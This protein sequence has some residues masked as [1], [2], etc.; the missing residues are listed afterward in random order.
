MNTCCVKPSVLTAL[1][2]QVK[3]RLHTHTQSAYFLQKI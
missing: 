2:H 1:V 3:L